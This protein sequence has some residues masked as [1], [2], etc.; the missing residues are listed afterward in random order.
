MLAPGV[1]YV[2]LRVS[3]EVNNGFVAVDDFILIPDVCPSPVSCDFEAN[4]CLWENV[5]TSKWTNGE[6]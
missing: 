1:W 3:L 2:E 5:E 4:T 6:W